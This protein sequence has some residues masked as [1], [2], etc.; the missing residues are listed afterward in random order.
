MGLSF[1]GY[2]IRKDLPMDVVVQTSLV[3]MYAMNGHLKLACYVFKN[4]PCKNVISWGALISGFAQNGFA[5]NALDLLVEM[6]GCGYRPDLVSLVSALLACTQVGFLKLGKSIHGYIVRRVD[7]DR[8]LGTAVIDMY[9]KCGAL[10]WARTLFDQINSKDSISW[11]AMIT[12]YGIHGHGKEALSLFLEM[13]K[14]NL[15]PDP[16][17]FSSLLSAFSHSGPVEEG[18]YWFNRMVS[19][20]KVPPTEKNYVCMV[21]LLARAG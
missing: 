13:T 19:E 2:L 8:V 10:S 1:H 11:N 4:M 18:Q 5:G 21:D 3:D 14:T 17:T 7:F 16:A 20:Y 6:Q 15:K 12:S 9:S